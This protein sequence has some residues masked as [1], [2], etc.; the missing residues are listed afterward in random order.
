M[1]PKILHQIW[2]GPHEIP[3]SAKN[4]CEQAK[5]QFKNYEYKFWNNDNLPNIP[6]KCMIQINKYQ[7]RK[8]Y[9]FV[10]DILR[11]YILNLYGGIYLD[12]D[13]IVYK[14]FS[15]IITKSFFC[16]N[17]NY[18]AYHVCNGIFG[19]EAH[20]PI[21]SKLLYELSDEPYHG[22]LLFS[23]YITEFLD[24]PQKTHIKK[25]LDLYPHDYI[26]CFGAEDFFRRNGKY[27]YH[28]ALHTWSN[29]GKTK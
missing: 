17:P 21:L 14:D 24:I 19:C 18:N 6:E 5:L 16:V 28:E 15:E 13:F 27:C 20:N 10:A 12:V 23:K 29:K 7:K 3:D 26:E 1:I 9:A 22:P 8:K 4:Y 25:H 2:I 11:Y